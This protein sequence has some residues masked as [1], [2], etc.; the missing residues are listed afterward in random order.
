[1]KK[2]ILIAFLI[3]IIF[4][5]TIF[6]IGGL[7]YLQLNKKPYIPSETYLKIHLKGD[8]QDI[9]TNVFSN[10]ELTMKKLFY[11]IMRAKI[12]NRVKGIIIKLS[13]INTSIDKALEIGQIL[14][15]FRKSKKKVYT[16]ILLKW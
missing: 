11:H 15:E 3:V 12:D 1:M 7:F 9:D 5:S 4:I 14:Q 10:K 13:P 6:I 2:G 16:F 8:I